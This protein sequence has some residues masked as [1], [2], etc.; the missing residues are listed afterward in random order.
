M[1]H[2]FI[3][4]AQKNIGQLG[5]GKLFAGG[6]TADLMVLAEN[7]PQVAAGKKDGS[8]AMLAGNA[9]FFAKVR[10]SSHNAG[11]GWTEAISAA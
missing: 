7:T 4:Q 9:G 8:R 3:L 10:G 5:N 11:K 6:C 1:M 2:A